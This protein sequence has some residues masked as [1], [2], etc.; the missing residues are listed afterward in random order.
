MY[1]SQDPIGLKGALNLYSY[2]GDPNCDIDILGLAIIKNK[3]EGLERKKIAYDKLKAEH[4]DA[5]ILS[6]RYLRGKDG[7]SVKDP[8]TGERRRIDYVVIEDGKVVKVVEVTSP[9]ADKTAQFEKE[10]RIKE[11]GGIFV[12]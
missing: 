2:V 12:R 8:A 11:N 5:T 7:K 10:G 3:S 4:P 1:I 9:T 6:E